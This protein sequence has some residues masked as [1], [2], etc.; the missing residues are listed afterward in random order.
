MRKY[1]SK[2]QKLVF[3][4]ILFCTLIFVVKPSI[5]LAVEIE[6]YPVLVK[7]VNQMVTEDDYPRAQLT[8]VLQQA[9]IQQSTLALINKPSEALPWYKYQ[10]IFLNQKR[11]N[12]GVKFWNEN[13][14]TLER[15]QQKFGV[16]QSVI[17]ALLGVE[18][19]YGKNLGGKRVLDSLVTLSATYPRRSKFFTAEL[20]IF[21]NITRKDN[22]DPVSVKGSFAGA[23]GIPQFMPSSYETY[24][25]DFNDNNQ[26]DLIN[27]TDDAIGSVA[28]YLESHGWNGIEAIYA[29]VAQPLSERATKLVKDNAKLE[30]TP[31]QLVDAGVKFDANR[32]SDK[33][34]LISFREQEG[35]RYI[36]G[37]R[38]FYV[39]TRYNHSVNYAMAVIDLADLIAQK[40]QQILKD[41]LP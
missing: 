41:A 9:K 7:L 12:Q 37:F 23:I 29:D 15:A 28:N 6:K 10:K 34:A 31:Q 30:H 25:I 18:T 40:K 35:H 3:F 1:S 27:E 17:V 14:L 20:R 32:S 16:P 36:V 19:Y 24:S 13:Q 11:V 8:Q 39:I 5:L 2:P 38:N 21:L 4:A 26:K 22:I 33:I